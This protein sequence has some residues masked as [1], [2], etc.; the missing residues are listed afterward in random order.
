MSRQGNKWILPLSLNHGK[1]TYKFIVDGE[2]IPDPANK[3]FEGNEHGTD[4]SVLW[5]EE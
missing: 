5:I 2:W 1:Y 3:L 4:N